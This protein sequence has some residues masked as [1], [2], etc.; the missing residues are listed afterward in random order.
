MYGQGI[1][2]ASKQKRREREN[3]FLDWPLPRRGP[4]RGQ[5]PALIIHWMRP[6]A[7]SSTAIGPFIWIYKRLTRRKT[8]RQRWRGARNKR[9]GS[10]IATGRW[11]PRSGRFRLLA[12][13]SVS[14]GRTHSLRSWSRSFLSFLLFLYVRDQDYSENKRAGQY[15]FLTILFSLSGNQISRK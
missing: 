8:K 7:T 10:R 2:M 4:L 9:S 3:E 15:N 6:N 1:W 12:P 5:R 11:P 14:S 13:L